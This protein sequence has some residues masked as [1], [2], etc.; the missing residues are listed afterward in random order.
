M[1]RGSQV[2]GIAILAVLVTAL[3]AVALRSPAAGHDT[4]VYA[5]PVTE[6]PQPSA[7]FVGDSYPAGTGAGSRQGSWACTTARELGWNCNLDA[8]GG[9]GFVADGRRNNGT[10]QPMIGRLPATEQ[11]YLADVV[12]VDAGRNDAT[13]RSADVA[14]AIAA[15]LRA[16]RAAWP[17]AQLVVIEP[18]FLNRRARVLSTFVTQRLR[19]ETERLDGQLID[20][21][22]EGWVP[23]AASSGL[24]DPDGVHPNPAGH[25]YIARHL[26][27]DLR[28]LGLADL[29]VTD[30]RGP[31]A[32]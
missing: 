10:S 23:P 12:V 1:S 9:T 17:K 3:C 21:V 5:A 14:G 6:A 11:R 4:V 20:P 28:R 29:P 26:T 30:Q 16:V 2:A 24:T 22:G 19:Q 13:F 32:G 7:L 27:A 15:Y 31:L 25:R 18:Y 8:Q